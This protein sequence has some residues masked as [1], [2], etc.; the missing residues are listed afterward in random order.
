MPAF[1]RERGMTVAEAMKVTLGS[2]ELVTWRSKSF[3]S[4]S[5]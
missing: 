5:G 1:K 2:P 4:Q 3:L